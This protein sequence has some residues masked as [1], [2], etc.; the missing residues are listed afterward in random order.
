[1]LWGM[2]QGKNIV[3]RQVETWRLRRAM[4]QKKLAT[5]ISRRGAKMDALDI[6]AI[7]TGQVK[8]LDY[9]LLALAKALDVT[10]NDLYPA[11]KRRHVKRCA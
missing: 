5:L 1:M 9:E 2:D 4:S 6:V 10:I 3:G 7:E 11:P 8:V